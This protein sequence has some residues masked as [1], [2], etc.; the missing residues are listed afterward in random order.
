MRSVR[1]L[2]FYALTLIGAEA[3][4]WGA[5]SLLRTILSGGLVGAAG[6]LAGGLSALIVG[7]PVFLF[8]WLTCARDARQDE[9][10]ASSRVRA[11]F[12]Y[13]IRAA[14]LVPILYSTLALF[15][16]ELMRLFGLSPQAAAFGGN[17]STVDNLVAIGVLAVAFAFFSRVL[18]ED[19]STAQSASLLPGTRRLYR[20]LWV[21]FGLTI[22]V[23][24]TQSLIRYLLNQPSSLSQP[25]YLLA[26]GL[27][28][29]L[30]GLPVWIW[31]WRLVNARQ[32][33][34]GERT[35]ALR[36]VVLHLISL[37]GLVGVLTAGG[38]VLSQLLS[39]IFGRPLTLSIFLTESNTFIAVGIPLS[40]VWVYHNRLLEGELEA[41][42]SLTRRES[43]RRLYR[44]ILSAL[45]MIIAFTG[46]L[47]LIEMVVDN[48]LVLGEMSTWTSISTGLAALGVGLPLWLSY[49]PGLQLESS[50]QD[51]KG[52]RA[53]RSVIRRTYLYLAVFALVVGG[54]LAAGSL[55]YSLI[56]RLLGELAGD[57]LRTVLQ[58]LLELAAIVA[59]LT[60]H[61]GALRADGRV[62]AQALGQK[63][64]AFPTL[65][66]ADG[67]AG[68]ELAEVIRR[69]LAR[70]AP[71]LPV[72]IHDLGQ[73]LPDEDCAA[74]RA[75][76]LSAS[77]AVEPGEELRRWLGGCTARRIVLPAQ[78]GDWTWLGVQPRTPR[79]L[80]REA[81]AAI[82]QT[83]EGEALR[84]GLPSSPWAIAGWVLGGILAFWLLMGLFSLV[85]QSLWR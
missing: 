71:L 59:F 56:S 58:R 68:L 84:A 60:Y 63:H 55:F 69:E 61:L 81:A 15:N 11:L 25:A 52:D 79:E 75:V 9:E 38:N 72:K 34:A 3:V 30:V 62:Q 35:S 77:L 70:Q 44:S 66:L 46:I 32:D 5:V 42:S 67:D 19:W 7:L 73:G 43:I 20:Y 40:V 13:T 31:T 24:G 29:V 37:A 4:V 2:Y 49:W 80:G 83:A 17:Q 65:L 47:V 85:I 6:Q 27:A 21:I 76:A 1:R 54:M 10:E 14:F 74:F 36:L 39:W 45:G 57:V 64:S 22:L 48:L 18:R 78:G 50:G 33:A 23:G 12:L 53:R 41:G 51:E 82:R 16:R 26:N 8:H 28:L